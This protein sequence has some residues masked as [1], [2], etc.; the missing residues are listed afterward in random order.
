LSDDVW[1]NQ[2]V[3]VRGTQ[4][5][6]RRR[7]RGQVFYWGHGLTSSAAREDQAGFASPIWEQLRAGWEVIRVDARGHGATNGEVG[8]DAYRWPELASDLLALASA[9]GHAR[10]VIGGVSMGAAVALHAAAA[11]PERIRALVLMTPPT[12]WTTRAAQASRYRANADL[13][14]REGLSALA[15]AEATQ[16]PVPILEGLFDPDEMAR[17]RYESQDVRVLP[18]ILRGVAASDFPAEGVVARLRQ[19][20]LLLAWDGDDSHPLSSARRL[21][22]LLPNATLAIAKQ[23]ADL[24][25]WPQLVAGFCSRQCA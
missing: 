13:A 2:F 11:A 18:S 15:R 5:A 16:P 3:S 24:Y 8:A 14:E 20:A 12:A 10:F 22:E 4:F 6:I 23:L 1:R 9:L 17:A 25:A 21:A 7:G 19:P